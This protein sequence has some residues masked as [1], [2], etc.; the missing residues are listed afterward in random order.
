[1]DIKIVSEK[2]IFSL[3]SVAF[4]SIKIKSEWKLRKFYNPVK[5]LKKFST[6]SIPQHA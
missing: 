5:L 1:M 4:S 2:Q 3:F 6:E